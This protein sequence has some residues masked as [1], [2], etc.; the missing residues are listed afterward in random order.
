MLVGAAP[1]NNASEICGL[2]RRMSATKHRQHATR[3]WIA[4]VVGMGALLFPAAASARSETASSGSV[5][6]VFS[7]TV[8]SG[9]YGKTFSSKRLRIFRGGAKVLDAP[10]PCASGSGDCDY[11]SPANY[12]GHQRS[13]RLVSVDSDREPEVIVDLFSGGAHCCLVTDLYDYRAY[14]GH[15]ARFARNWGDPGYHLKSQGARRPPVFVTGDDRFAYALTA[16]VFSRWP[17]QILTYAHGRFHDATRRFGHDVAVNARRLW[18]DFRH[19]RRDRDFDTRGVLAAYVADDYLLGRRG[20]AAAKLRRALRSGDLR[21][22]NG[23]G[24]KDPSPSG[25]H[26][27]DAL[28]R[29]LRRHGYG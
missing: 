27:I 17:I 9:K 20:D 2:M 6:A 1:A 15:Y 3:A 19:L 10:V 25:Q 18:R 23:P 8:H 7:Y 28:Q 4:A 5:R 14:S 29:F 22:R 21:A 13:V 16:F 11:E 24:Y 12:Y 26:Y